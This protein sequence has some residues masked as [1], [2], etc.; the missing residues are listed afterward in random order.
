MTDQT[1]EIIAGRERAL[2][3]AMLAFDYAAL[4][5]VLSDDVSYIHSTGV[6]EDKAAYFAGLRRGEYE[7][8]DLER[9]SGDT[10]VFAGVAI[11]TGVITML[12]GAKGSTKST[13]RLQRAMAT[14]RRSVSSK[15]CC[16]ATRA[17]SASRIRMA[18]KIALCSGNVTV[19]FCSASRLVIRME[20]MRLAF[21]ACVTGS[22]NS[23]RAARRQATW[24]PTSASTK[25]GTL[26]PACTMA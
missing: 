24:K 17:A 4:D 15:C 7:Y 3:K 10:R 11:T 12:V 2:Y 23:L 22:R 25:S 1:H 8:G 6:V 21:M 13:I 20:V 26:L 18:S 16:I 5:A 19:R 9:I 14:R